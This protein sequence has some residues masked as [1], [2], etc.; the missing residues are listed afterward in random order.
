M[1]IYKATDRIPVVI[2][3]V[4]LF[5]SPLSGK[6]RA[7]ILSYTKMKGGEEVTDL[8]KMCIETLRFCI[9]GMEAPHVLDILGKQYQF[10]FED[11]GNLDEQSVDALFQIVEGEKLIQVASEMISKR[12]PKDFVV[13][14]VTIEL[15]NVFTDKKK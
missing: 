4:K 10:T 9:K 11:N 14:G 13:P 5:I 3:E 12:S 8:Q 1:V 15:E 7:E 2:G 6:Q